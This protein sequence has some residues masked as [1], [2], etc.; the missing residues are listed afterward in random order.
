[1]EQLTYPVTSFESVFTLEDTPSELS[2]YDVNRFIQ[3]LL[4][5]IDIHKL[6]SLYFQHLQ[7]KLGL[8]AI[9]LQFSTGSLTLG[10]TDKTCN[11]KTLDFAD[12]LKSFASAHYSF[13]QVLSISQKNAL[14][15][16]HGYFCSPLKNALDYYQLKQLAMKD[17][18]TALG[19]R[20]NYQETLMRLVS[21]AK[22]TD[23][24]FGL[25]VI[26]LDN[27]KQVNDLHGHQ[28]GDSVL[29]SMADILTQTLRDTDYAFRFGGDEFCCLL[30][31]SGEQ[32]NNLVARRILNAVA[33]HALMTRFNVSC[34]IGSTT[35]QT[36]D[37]SVTL[38]SRADQA[39]YAA[40]NA[41]RSCIKAA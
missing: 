5:T 7:Q 29:Q 27:F 24:S 31:G 15:E 12:N 28:E 11:I 32:Q 37:T 16:L 25:L 4:S 34:S 21:D 33:R 19:N 2:Q 13:K 17:H 10:D 14:N 18:L 38:F 8:E 20:A 23:N 1:M 41:G 35:Y 39:L 26:D 6:A 30:P 3:Q 40:K 9:R 36:D 22:R